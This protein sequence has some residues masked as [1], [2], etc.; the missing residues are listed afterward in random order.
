MKKFKFTLILKKLSKL[1]T[2]EIFRLLK[3]Y[4]LNFEYFFAYLYNGIK[5]RWNLPILFQRNYMNNFHHIHFLS[6][7]ITNV[8][9][10]SNTLLNFKKNIF[11]FF[12]AINYSI[13]RNIHFFIFIKLVKLVNH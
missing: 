10:Y 5:V 9:L 13:K 2:F 1:P 6:N 12:L 11:L 3:I 4:C 7:F 8:I